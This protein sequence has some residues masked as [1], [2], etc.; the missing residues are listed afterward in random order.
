MYIIKILESLT[1]HYRPT[2]DGGGGSIKGIYPRSPNLESPTRLKYENY[3]WG[4]RYI[5]KEKMGFEN[6][7]GIMENLNYIQVYIYTCVTCYRS[8]VKFRVVY[9][10]RYVIMLI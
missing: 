3:D 9:L 1:H 7:I 10:Y 8:G 2:F 5:K 4:S 6:K